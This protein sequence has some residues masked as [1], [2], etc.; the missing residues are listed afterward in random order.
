MYIRSKIKM[1]NGQVYEQHQLLKSIR[2][3]LGPRQE[4]ILNLGTLKLPKDQW[5]RLA[6]AIESKWNNQTSFFKETPEI[7]T[8]AS[9]FAQM[10]I[11]KELNKQNLS[12]E[13]R[14]VSVWDEED[15]DEP[16]EV[17][18]EAPSEAPP[19]EPDYERVDIHSMKTTE[20]KSIGAEQVIL[21]QMKR[22]GF[23]GILKD[24]GMDSKRIEVA[25]LLIVGRAA[26]PSSERELARWVNANSGIQELIGSDEKVYDNA[27]HRTAV[28]LWENKKRIEE[29]LR[30]RAK[31]LFS[32]DEKVILYDLT[33]T[34]F[35]GKKEG[36]LIA[37]FGKSKEKRRDC[38][39]ATL[40]LVVDSEGFPKESHI[41][42]GNISEPKTFKDIL[43]EIRE[44]GEGE[45]KKTI[46]IDAGIATDENLALIRKEKMSYVAISRK[47]RYP[48]SLWEG[49]EEK[50]VLLNDNKTELRL[51]LALIDTDTEHKEEGGK[52]GGEEGEPSP[53]E[54]FLLC[55]SPHKEKKEKQILERRMHSFEQA[56]KKLQEGLKNPRAQKRYD[57]IMERIGRLKERHRVGHCF[58]ITVEHEN[59]LVQTIIFKENLKAKAQWEE[60][61]EYVIRT[62]RLD[63]EEASISSIHRSLSMIE[64]SF[65]SM[66]SEL[67]MRPNYHKKE[68][69][70]IAHIFITVIAYQMV[71]A[72]LKR[73]SDGGINV[74]WNT[75]RNILD[76]HDRVVTTFNTDDDHCI[77]IRNTTVPNANQKKIYNAL[78][79]KHDPLKNI[80]LK[81]KIQHTSKM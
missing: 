13:D 26:H 47:Q 77:Y 29:K 21:D 17:P 60:L 61:G 33:N 34:Y 50:K 4:V 15:I 2:T 27:L 56:L 40:A 41:L 22:Y 9:H 72:I 6:N 64:S 31:D 18:P 63:L 44:M 80:K 30:K 20:S 78:R 57:R 48:A 51:K 35:E 8:L 24:L 28:A 10:I 69:P 62:N 14:E 71:C 53:R 38:K 37:Q 16:P 52:E 3:P 32:L 59:N 68:A 79:I 67:G 42:E 12:K 66:K 45:E 55:Q 76:S 25:K 1:R 5:K 70:T 46:V 11:S 19:E 7:E 23:D 65:R 73:L 36:S 54:A 81:R 39:L 75:V 74:T 43:K 58:D 49:S